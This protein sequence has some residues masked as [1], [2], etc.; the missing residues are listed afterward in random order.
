MPF[1]QT[2]ISGSLPGGDIFR[3]GFAV[4]TGIGGEASAQEIADTIASAFNDNW[5]K[6]LDGFTF[7]IKFPPTVVFQKILVYERPKT[8]LGASSEQAEATLGNKAGTSSEATLPPECAVCVSL[9]TG[10]PGRSARG[11]MYLPPVAKN[12]I[13]T[14]GQLGT[15]DAKLFAD[16]AAAF[17]GQINNIATD[18]NVVVWSR[19]NA[20]TRNVT[21]VQVG[22]QIDMQRRRQNSAPE[23]YQATDVSIL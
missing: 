11:R 10:A 1:F 23:T 13:G 9:L 22:N 4:E 16:W 2:A 15:S 17:F 14:N 21:R 19:K 20:S 12:V 8:P 5:L 6:V 7:A 18:A 3:S